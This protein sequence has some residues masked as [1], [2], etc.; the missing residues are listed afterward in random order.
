M[1]DKLIFDYTEDTTPARTDNILLQ[2]SIG[3]LYTR[4]TLANVL[5]QIEAGDYAV[6]QSN[7]YYVGKHG[8][9]S[10]AGTS[11]ELAYLTFSAAITA[12]SSGDA[13]VCLDGGTYAEGITAKAGVEVFAPNATLDVTGSQLVMAEATIVFDKVTRASG[14]N[15]MILFDGATGRQKLTCNVIDDNG[16]GIGI[17]MTNASIPIVAFKELYVSGGGTGIADFTASQHY[18][19]TGRDLYLNSDNAVGIHQA[20]SGNNGV[21][22]IQHI[23]E[24]GTRTGT[25]ALDIDAGAVNLFCHEIVADTAWDVE[26]GA[27]LNIV[28]CSATGT[29]LNDGTVNKWITDDRTQT[30]GMPILFKGAVS[31]GD[32]LVALNLPKAI[33]ITKVTSKSTAGTC[34]ATVKIGSTALGGTANSVSTT[35]QEQAHS[36]SNTAAAGDD[37]TVTVSAN[38]S[39]ENMSLMIEYTAELD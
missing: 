38:S 9:D 24:I 37:I 11:P 20:V 34:T 8:N 31:D 33:T 19:I 21:A 16:S 25:V 30:Y 26:S 18:H 14:A 13:V 27:V 29:K 32:Y 5:A 4:A 36:T 2:G 6:P 15:A 10:N 12:A 3:T 35:Q 17:R 23:V 7:V 28:G 1:A 39:C 22:T